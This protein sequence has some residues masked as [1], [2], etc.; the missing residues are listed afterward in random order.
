MAAVALPVNVILPAGPITDLAPILLDAND[1]VV[2]QTP[3]LD[4]EPAAAAGGLPRVSLPLSQAF[5]AF[6]IKCKLDR[7]PANM[8]A[9]RPINGLT[10]RLNAV[11]WSRVLTAVRDNG[12]AGKT[13]RILEELHA[14]IR[15]DVPITTITAADWSPAP[16]LGVGAN[17][18]DRAASAQIR[19]LSLASVAALEAQTGV[20]ATAAPWTAICKLVGAMGGVSTQASRLVETSMIQSVAE[21]VR[22]HSSGG[23]T[24]A[25]LSFNLRSNLMRAILP[26]VLRAH[27][28]TPEEQH[29][30]LAD[31][32]AYK[33]SDADRKSVEQTRIYYILPW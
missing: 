15:S 22:T 13:L 24:D 2:T 5:A 28:V 9:A 1:P 7:S 29:E 20:L 18:A 26:K 31:A 33:V 4:W 25:A 21:V 11:A 19:F 14:H 8:A 12:L 3:W 16:A 27:G 32:F 10:I 17:A 23:G 30:E 6:A